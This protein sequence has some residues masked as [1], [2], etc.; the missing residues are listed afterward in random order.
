MKLKAGDVVTLTQ[1][2][3]ES[4]WYKKWQG[5]NGNGPFLATGVYS[6]DGG[7]IIT[8]MDGSPERI[9]TGQKLGISRDYLQKDRFLTAAH[10][11]TKGKESA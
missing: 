3:K 10:K 7:E 11:A 8:Q 6:Q 1:T 5:L 9:W 4:H 2:A